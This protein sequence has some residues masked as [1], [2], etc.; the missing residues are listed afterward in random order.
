[1]DYLDLDDYDSNHNHDIKISWGKQYPVAVKE[2]FRIREKCL[3]LSPT[4]KWK[5]TQKQ[6][7][8]VLSE[9]LLG[10]KAR[11]GQAGKTLGLMFI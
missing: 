4:T 11:M 3:S 10:W 9:T 6:L 7:T 5:Q 2:S 8:T 1:M